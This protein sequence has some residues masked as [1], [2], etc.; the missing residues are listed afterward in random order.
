M[1]RTRI[2]LDPEIYR[3]AQDVT[4]RQ[5]ISFA[6]LCRQALAQALRQYENEKNEKPWMR[7]AGIIETGSSDSSQSVDEVVYG[8][9][10]P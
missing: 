10:R 1:I 9:Q 3:K 8:R 5:G 6:E 4:K 2:S 7:F